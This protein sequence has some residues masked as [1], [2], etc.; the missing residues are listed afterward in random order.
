MNKIFYN[1]TQNNPTMMF[2]N[3]GNRFYRNIIDKN[4]PLQVFQ[5]FGTYDYWSGDSDEGSVDRKD[6]AVEETDFIEDDDKLKKEWGKA[7]KHLLL[8]C[9]NVNKQCIKSFM[10]VVWSSRKSNFL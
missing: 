9:L 6:K 7:F 2:F 10:S 5:S 3:F 8:S 4:F 1:I